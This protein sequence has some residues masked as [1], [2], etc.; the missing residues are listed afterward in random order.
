MYYKLQSNRCCFSFVYYYCIIWLFVTTAAAG[1]TN[2]VVVSRGKKLILNRR[3]YCSCREERKEMEAIKF[4]ENNRKR[5]YATICIHIIIILTAAK[6]M[7][8]S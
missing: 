7:M 6:Y 5:T 4:D 3:L 8:V 1:S 2:C